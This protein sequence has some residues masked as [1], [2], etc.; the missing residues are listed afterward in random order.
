MA[1]EMKDI[2]PAVR[3][4]TD[5]EPWRFSDVERM[6]E[7]WFDH[8]WS[9]PLPRMWR[10][11]FWRLRP[12]SMTAPTLDFYEEK[13][14]LIVK[15]EIPGMTKDEID[16]SLDGNMLTIKGEK[17]KE[18][19][20][21]EEN[22]YHCERTFGSFLRTVELPM[23]VKPD[24]VDASFKNGVLEIRLPKAEEAKKN[25]FKVKVA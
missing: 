2:K 6:F 20:V 13:D 23:G 4:G 3:R 19:E 1:K 7:D 16:I 25:V 5:V 11:D 24:K 17:K 12:I 22:Y 14:D 9:R 8:F 15:A 10:P 21:K 18:E